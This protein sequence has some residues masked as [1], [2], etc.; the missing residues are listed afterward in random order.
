[1]SNVEVQLHTSIRQSLLY[2]TLLKYGIVIGVVGHMIYAFWAHRV[3]RTAREQNSME[4][5][6]A[7]LYGKVGGGSANVLVSLLRYTVLLAVLAP[8]IQ[9]AMSRA[10]S[11]TP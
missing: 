7:L 11:R 1:M 8:V 6:R 3:A 10:V 5:Q 2:A 9:F 4:F